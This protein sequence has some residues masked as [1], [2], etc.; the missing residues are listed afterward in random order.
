M[1]LP[2]VVAHAMIWIDIIAQ[3]QSELPRDVAADECLVLVRLEDPPARFHLEAAAG[4]IAELRKHLG[5]R[6]DDAISLVVVAYSVRNSQRDP[7][8]RLH[9]LVH[10]P[11]DVSR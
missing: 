1:H 7:R 2:R 4:S 6:A 11:R 5:R 10:R 9:L 3:L 8:V